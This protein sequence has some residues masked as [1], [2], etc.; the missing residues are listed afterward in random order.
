MSK[1]DKDFIDDTSSQE[2]NGF[3]NKDKQ[4]ND[5]REIYIDFVRKGF[6]DILDSI[7]KEKNYLNK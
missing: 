2:D 1:Q 6:T 3:V 5:D 7:R 4:F